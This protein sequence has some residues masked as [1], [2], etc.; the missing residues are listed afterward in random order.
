MST[1]L[2]LTRADVPL[3]RLVLVELRKAIDTLAGR[4]LLISIAII[5]VL[6]DLFWLG[7]PQELHTVALFL[8]APA[9]LQTPLLGI[10]G[11]LLATSEWSQ[12]TA[13]VT[14]TLVPK[15]SRTVLA[16]IVAALALTTIV[17]AL[18]LAVASLLAAVGGA[19]DPW[20]L[21][22]GA[23][24]QAY[25]GA[26]ISTFKGVGF[27]LLLLNTP[28]AI[29]AFLLAPL[30]VAS[31]TGLVDALRNA[32]PWVNFGSAVD[33]LYD[34]V[35]GMLTGEQWAHLVSATVIWFVIPFAIGI[36]RVLTTE[37]K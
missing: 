28:A 2:D 14:F 7:R 32:A 11:I 1:E 17:F 21:P 12:R 9:V 24:G 10:M 25:L 5:T 8:V 18:S 30:V 22:P 34:Q 4:W 31:I 13:M 23:L 27:G 26:L 29:V 6:W 36:W 33:P 20:D 16:K 37:V 19:T 3:L 15:R 35:P